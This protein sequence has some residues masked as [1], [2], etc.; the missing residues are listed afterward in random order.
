[1]FLQF[2]DIYLV[3]F[4]FFLLFFGASTL[5]TIIIFQGPIPKG[6][7]DA[8][9]T[10]LVW[11]LVVGSWRKENNKWIPFAHQLPSF[12]LPSIMAKLMP[13]A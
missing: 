8:G 11:V 9:F 12:C 10:G 2:G 1:M 5:H 13:L 6:Y 7:I 4:L 3:Y